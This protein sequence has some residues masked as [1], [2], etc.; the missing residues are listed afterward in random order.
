[1]KI[2]FDTNTWGEEPKSFE[3]RYFS[4]GYDEY[5]QPIDI[6][7]GADKKTLESISKFSR[8]GWNICENDVNSYLPFVCSYKM[9]THSALYARL[10]PF[11]IIKKNMHKII[12][13]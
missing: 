13:Y 8:L 12:Y 9:C 3:I 2:V 7:I 6:V 10:A 5:I 4:C 1:M 11:K